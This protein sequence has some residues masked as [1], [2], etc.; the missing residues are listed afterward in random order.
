VVPA[1][2]PARGKV[3]ESKQGRGDPPAVPALRMGTIGAAAG[4]LLGQIPGKDTESTLAGAGV[5]TVMGAVVALTS[6]AG[7]AP[8]PEGSQLRVRCDSPVGMR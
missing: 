5:G 8:L 2:A 7:N 3:R 1:G 6:R 4:A